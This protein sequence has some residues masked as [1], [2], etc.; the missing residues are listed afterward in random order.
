VE[1]EQNPGDQVEAPACDEVDDAEEYRRLL[2]IEDTPKG[3]QGSPGMM[4]SSGGYGDMM[5]YPGGAMPY[6]P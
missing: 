4:P 3:A 1:Q 2:F 6:G 5:G